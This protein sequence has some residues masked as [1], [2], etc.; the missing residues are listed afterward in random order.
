MGVLHHLSDPKRGLR[1]VAEVLTEDGFAFLYLYGALGGR[2]RMRRTQVLEILMGEDRDDFEVGIQLAKDLGFD[3]FEY[4]WSLDSD[5]VVTDAQIV[6]A[7]LN[8]NETLYVA[9]SIHD[10][11]SEAGFY[12]YATYG[13]T[14]EDQGLLFNAGTKRFRPSETSIKKFLRSDA[15]VQR[16]ALLSVRERYR[17]IDLFY[18]PNGYTRGR[19][20][21]GR[22]HPV[23]PQQR[24]FEQAWSSAPTSSRQ[25]QLHAERRKVPL[26]TLSSF[27]RGRPEDV[28]P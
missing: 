7:Y 21:R 27:N 2:E 11:V 28:M 1:N 12:A 10:L 9:D 16:F 18:Q 8:V 6:D 24:P 19:D 26:L 13:I 25:T 3:K 17:L 14:I 20:D 4:G 22:E 15:A 23:C 5:D